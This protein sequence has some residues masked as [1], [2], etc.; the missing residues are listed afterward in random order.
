[1]IYEDDVQVVAEPFRDT[2]KSKP[3]EAHSFR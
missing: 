1:L 3:P 2:R